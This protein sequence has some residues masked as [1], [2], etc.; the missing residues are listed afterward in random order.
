MMQ[1]KPNLK[2]KTENQSHLIQI[3]AC[4]IFF[5]L[6]MKIEYLIKKKMKINKN[7]QM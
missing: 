2:K 7:I 5:D 4:L 3:F 6:T 1:T